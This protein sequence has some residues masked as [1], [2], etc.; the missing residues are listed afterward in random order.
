RQAQ[1]AAEAHARLRA[2]E[3]AKTRAEE[4]KARQDKF[5]AILA[6]DMRNPLSVIEL[7][8]AKMRR[9]PT[10]EDCRNL[11]ARV[12]RSAERMRALVA[13]VVDFAH[14]HFGGGISVSQS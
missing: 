2:S 1:E 6:H 10:C 11:G 8:T 14:G 7:T 4:A 3:A 9:S 12:A 13:D 5:L